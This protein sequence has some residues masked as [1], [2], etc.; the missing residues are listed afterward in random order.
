MLGIDRRSLEIGIAETI[1]EEYNGTPP[2]IYSEADLFNYDIPQCD[3]LLCLSLVMYFFKDREDTEA[4]DLID[5]IGRC[6]P[7]MYLDCGGMY[8]NHLPFHSKDA[9]RAIVDR[10]TYTSWTLLG[11]TALESRPLF[12]IWR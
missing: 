4:W 9:G 5:R 3:V 7:K 8:A 11:T 1:M 2:P 6:S 12:M 10:S